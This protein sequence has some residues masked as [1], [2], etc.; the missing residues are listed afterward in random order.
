M[1]TLPQ[2]FKPLLWSYDFSRINPKKD[3]KL[4]II[5]TINYGDLEQWRWLIRTYG[6]KEIKDILEH[7]PASE[8]RRHV[9]RLVSLIFNVEYHNASR[10]PR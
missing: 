8:I 10:S 2:S 1:K 9:H 3:K 7:V 4:I 5:N 6:K